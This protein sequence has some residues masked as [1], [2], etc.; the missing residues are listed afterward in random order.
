M[1]DRA[2]PPGVVPRRPTV[3]HVYVDV[4]PDG[5]RVWIRMPYDERMLAQFKTAIG[6]RRWEKAA[7]CWSIGRREWNEAR[8]VIQHCWSTCEIHYTKAAEVLSLDAMVEEVEP[9]LLCYEILGVRQSAP[10]WLVHEAYDMHCLA[11]VA[12]HFHVWLPMLP[13]SPQDEIDTDDDA[14]RLRN[15]WQEVLHHLPPALRAQAEQTVATFNLDEGDLTTL[16]P[17]TFNEI[18]D[19]YVR[20]CKHRELTP[21]SPYVVERLPQPEGHTLPWLKFGRALTRAR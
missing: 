10:D 7:K 13:A 15:V 14:A 9:D 21:Q 4:Q 19:A 17:Y 2:L 8:R 6:D 18:D 20:V 12:Q 5:H 16:T 11:L 3:Q 1:A